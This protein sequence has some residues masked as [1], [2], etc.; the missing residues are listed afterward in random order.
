MKPQGFLAI[1]MGSTCTKRGG[2][3]VVAGADSLDAASDTEKGC[4]G[5]L[6]GKP[7]DAQFEVQLQSGATKCFPAILLHT[8]MG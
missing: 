1:F 7:H 8:Q 4:K 6:A 5:G 2:A 3:K